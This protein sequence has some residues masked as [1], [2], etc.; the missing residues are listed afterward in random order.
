[1]FS[2][3][4]K[5]SGER[6][7]AIARLMNRSHSP[8]TDWAL[9]HVSIAATDYVLD[10]GC[11]GGRTVQKLAAMTSQGKVTGVDYADGSVSVARE[12]NADAIAS[13]RVAIDHGSVEKLPYADRAFDLATAIE[14]FYYWPDPEANLREVLRV[15][16]PGGRL[17]L[18]AESYRRGSAPS[19]AG[20]VM[21]W[22]LRGK[23]LSVAE[24]VALLT[25]A[26]FRDVSTD[27]NQ[28]K[29]WMCAIGKRP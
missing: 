15:L 25:A 24:H 16:R 9:E 26:G 18:V 17:L 19:V 10:I 6:G 23:H 21:T 13:G 20:R 3:L 29:G 11:G 7:Q 8:L 14:T 22:L 2:Q 28:P 5:P 27:E 4:R 1:M 12:T